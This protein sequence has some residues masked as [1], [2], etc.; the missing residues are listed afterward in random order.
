MK[1]KAITRGKPLWNEYWTF[2]SFEESEDY[3]KRILS[4]TNNWKYKI[5]KAWGKWHVLFFLADD[6]D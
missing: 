2:D 6:N 4:I 5:Y 3:A 1:N